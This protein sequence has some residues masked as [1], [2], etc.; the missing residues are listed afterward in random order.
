MSIL[1]SFLD[2]SLA[3]SRLG[4]KWMDAFCADICE[5]ARTTSYME[6]VGN[7][8]DTLHRY[9]GNSDIRALKRGYELQLRKMLKR[10]NLK[11]VELAIDGKK[12]PY[13][14]KELFHTRRTK[15]ERGTNNSWEYI[16]LSVVWPI[17]VPLM[18]IPYP[19]GADLAE[20]CI[21]LLEFARSLQLTIMN[22]L[23][24]RGF[25]NAHLIDYLQSRKSKKPIPYLILVPRDKAIKRYIIETTKKMGVFEHKMKYSKEKST[26]KPKTTI[27]VCKEVGKNRKGELYDM[28]FATNLKPSWSLIRRY[29]RRWNIE[30]G[31]RIMEE[32][33][34]MTKS[35]NPLIRYFYF[36]LRGLLTLLWTVSN[37]C[38]T[39]LTYKR[40]LCSIEKELRK[41]IVYKPPAILPDY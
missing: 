4:K 2:K 24:D 22:V 16:Q 23:F 3:L 33:K 36:L 15:Y 18:A 13:Y 35:N 34:I 12:D 14:G 39:E 40:Y 25:Y 19:Q 29:R 8:A 41:W 11:K 6:T 1:K 32:G 30:T 27:V 5:S 10:L 31:F 21:E 28:I 9:I 20:I 26:W 7:K 38:K 17:R 37:V